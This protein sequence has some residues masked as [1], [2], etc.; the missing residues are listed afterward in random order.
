ME[1]EDKFVIK[2]FNKVFIALFAV[3]ITLFVL[4]N[5]FVNSLDLE[6]RKKILVVFMVWTL[7][8][9]FVYKYVLY[10]DKD[11][12]RI[13][14]EANAG[15]FLWLNEL[16]LHLCNINIILIPAGIMT[17]NR[18]ILGSSLF[19]GTIGAFLAM[20]TPCV[21][22]EKYS[23]FLPRVFCFFLTHINVMFGSIALVTFGIYQPEYADTI[24]IVLTTLSLDFIIFLVNIFLRKTKLNIYANYFYNM[25]FD[26]IPAVSWIYRLIPVP[27][28]FHVPLYVLYTVLILAGITIINIFK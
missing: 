22:F 14:L 25:D 7:I 15:G 17:S 13:Q 11:Y 3:C 5:L 28:L 2:T 1:K 23:L 8:I 26:S 20:L 16:P 10:K 9:F 27:F 12:H 6:I 21:G 18:F 24:K 19:S 4:V